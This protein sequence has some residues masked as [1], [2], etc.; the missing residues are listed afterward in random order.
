MTETRNP[1]FVIA[2]SP[3]SSAFGVICVIFALR[4]SSRLTYIIEFKGYGYQDEDS[5]YKWSL[6]LIHIVQLVG[7][8]VGNIAPI[9]RCFTFIGH[10]S[11]SKKLSKNH[12]NVFWVEKHWI[13]RLQHWKR[14]HVHSHIPS[15]YLK[16]VF[17]YVKNAFLN[18][19]LALHIVLLVICKTIVLVP[20][21]FL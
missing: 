17:H 18:F 15:R 2:C 16:I 9:L 12:L 4:S 1:Q 5:D 8:V 11:L 20:R 13:E 14:N 21:A 19:C 3:V 10:Y 6:V 7:V